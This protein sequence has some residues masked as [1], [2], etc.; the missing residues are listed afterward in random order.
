MVSLAQVAPADQAGR[1]KRR[2]YL[3]LPKCC[4]SFCAFF[5]FGIVFVPIAT[6]LICALFA[7]PLWA[8]ECAEVT[9]LYGAA[10]VDT[11]APGMCSYYEWWKYIIGNLVGVG[12]LTEVALVT[13]N[14]LVEIID[15][16]IATWSLTVAGLVIGL[17]GSLAW[18]SLL[19]ET[20]DEKVTGRMGKLL[21]F[22]AAAEAAATQSLDFPAFTAMCNDQGLSL[23]DA[24]MRE[25]FDAAD[26]DGSGT[27]DTDEVKKLIASV[28]VVVAKGG[29]A[30]DASGSGGAAVEE[31]AARMDAMDK[32]LEKIIA[33]LN[34]SPP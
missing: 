8:I 16:L 31:L 28:K 9:E 27:I 2:R 11:S 23:D 30:K 24:K 5:I 26:E 25:L 22:E 1:A 29:G 34:A 17:V 32:K 18:V 6:F 13:G 7:L 10:N 20:A 14:V 33:L 21:G 3:G 19:T 4:A 15:L 12:D